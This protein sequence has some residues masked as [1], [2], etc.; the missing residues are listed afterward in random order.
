[1]KT[2]SFTTKSVSASAIPTLTG[3]CST[4]PAVSCFVTSDVTSTCSSS[5]TAISEMTCSVTLNAGSPPTASNLLTYSVDSEYT[6]DPVRMVFAIGTDAICTTNFKIVIT[7]C[8]AT[9]SAK[10]G[11]VV[12]VISYNSTSQW[13][14]TGM[15]PA[16]FFYNSKPT[17]CPIT[18]CAL[19]AAN[20]SGTTSANIVLHYSNKI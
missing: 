9:L 18:Y 16:D 13:F 17:E 14:L 4:L 11:V 5:L 12:P 20:C 8:S 10:S 6:K 15:G 7:D 2:T 3:D 1:M 19:K